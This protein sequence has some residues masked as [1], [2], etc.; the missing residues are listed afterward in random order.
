MASPEASNPNNTDLNHPSRGK[1]LCELLHP[2]EDA[3]AFETTKSLQPVLSFICPPEDSS[4]QISNRAFL[5]NLRSFGAQ[6]VLGS[7]NSNFLK[8]TSCA[9]LPCFMKRAIFPWFR[10]NLRL[11]CRVLHQCLTQSPLQAGKIH[12]WDAQIWTSAISCQGRPPNPILLPSFFCPKFWCSILTQCN[13]VWIQSA[14]LFLNSLGSFLAA[15]MPFAL[16]CWLPFDAC[17]D[18]EDALLIA[19]YSDAHA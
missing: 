2:S 1:R 10:P 9:S 11:A 7:L 6:L 14:Q 12:T 5:P 16:A 8:K 15:C 4:F 3:P 17:D 19:D 18:R 13:P